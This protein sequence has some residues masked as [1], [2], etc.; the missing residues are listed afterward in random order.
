MISSRNELLTFCQADRDALLAA[1]CARRGGCTAPPPAFILDELLEDMLGMTVVPRVLETHVL[2]HCDFDDRQVCYNTRMRQFSLPNT[3]IEGL[4]HS[5]LGHELGHLRLGHEAELRADHDPMTPS[6]FGTAA[7]SVHLVCGRSVL[8]AHARR[9]QNADYYAAVFL[10][11]ERQLIRL[12]RGAIIE[13]ARRSGRRM[14]SRD[15]WPMVLELADHF[16]VTGALMARRMEDLGWLIK[17]GPNLSI[18][19]QAWLPLGL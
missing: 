11:P 10:V 17:K 7:P 3:K 18:H 12:E 9:E 4:V 5:T 8:P 19:P 13:E 2:G 16:G 6:M 15:L 14:A 1:W